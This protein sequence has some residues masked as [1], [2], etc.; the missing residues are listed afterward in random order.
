MDTLILFA[1]LLWKFTVEKENFGELDKS[2]FY[3]PLKNI[4]F[5]VSLVVIAFFSL[6][7]FPSSIVRLLLLAAIIYA[8]EIHRLSAGLTVVKKVLFKKECDER[9]NNYFPIFFT[10][11][12]VFVILFKYVTLGEYFGKELFAILIVFPITGAFSSILTYWLYLSMSD[13]TNYKK[14]S[15]VKDFVVSLVVILIIGLALLRFRFF[16]ILGCATAVSVFMGKYLVYKNGGID[17]NCLAVI[18][19]TSELV[20]L[21]AGT[22]V[23]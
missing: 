3:L 12:I 22:M 2:F 18:A 5:G 11:T 17:K 19:E 16:L 1:R 20:A 15:D 10:A 21:L 9:T 6:Y 14:N 4:I 7:Y 8:T 13:G 23:L